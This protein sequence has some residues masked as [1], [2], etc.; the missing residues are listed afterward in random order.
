[1]VVGAFEAKTHLPQLLERVTRGE[2]IT[3]TRHGVPIAELCPLTAVPISERE[4]AIDK[5]K[6]FRQGKSA[7][8]E[9]RR[10]IAEGRA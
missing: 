1:M 5:L 10:M 3:I 2:R 9:S 6:R 4:E 7:G 8:G